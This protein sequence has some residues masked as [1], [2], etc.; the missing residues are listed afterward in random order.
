MKGLRF[1]GDRKAAIVDYPDPEPRPGEVVI[2]IKVAGMC[3]SDLHI[4]RRS[5][6][7]LEKYY[8]GGDPP[9]IPKIP[10]HEPCGIVEKVGEGVYHV[11]KG[12]PV[13]I[14]HATGCGH[15][16]PCLDGYMQY[17]DNFSYLLGWKVHG[18]DAEYMRVGAAGV[19]KLPP[20]IS[21][22]D[23]A[24]IACAGG[25]AYNAIK[26]LNVTG[27]DTLVLIG[28]GP[29]S[30]C[31]TLIA[32]AMGATVIAVDISDER[33]KLI[34]ELGAD[35]T[36]NSKKENAVDKILT[37]TR[38]KGEELWK[39]GISMYHQGADAAIETSATPEGAAMAIA[40]V[41]VHGRVH[42]LGSIPKGFTLYTGDLIRKWLTV[43]GTWIFPIGLMQ[44][45]VKFMQKHKITF[46][47]TV[48]HKFPL[49][50]GPEAFELFDK[51]TIGKAILIP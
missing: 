11:K 22:I 30:M 32:K 16:G 31:A 29:V 39:Q 33:L 7:E 18:A 9:N 50:K 2:K 49:I 37:L 34:R 13:M 44:E 5:P 26:T 48:T 15:C 23:G 51:Q 10:G 38:N 27:K 8:Q 14:F 1:Y 47:K 35:Y 17:C 36:I 40:C 19:Q 6:E 41:R 4:Y 20:G 28:S 45:L 43:R 46:E 12:D 3:G 25:T 21:F 24:I 42:F